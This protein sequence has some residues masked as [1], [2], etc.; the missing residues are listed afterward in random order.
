MKPATHYAN[1]V[2]SA[3]A[4]ATARMLADLMIQHAIG[5]VVIRDDEQRPIGIVTDRDLLC[6]VVACG[7]DPEQTPA[8]EIATKPVH[9]VPNDQPL[10]QVIAL[11]RDANV[12]RAPVVEGGRLVG[13]VTLDDLV[14]QLSREIASLS[15]AATRSIDD[16]LRAGRWKR[17]RE[18]FEDALA[19]L[20]ASAVSAGRE[21]A[22]RVTRELDKLRERLR[23]PE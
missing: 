7:L 2:A 10:E 13:I 6:R 19:S 16:T 18:E 12:R 5:C 3:P 15:T 21:V 9:C 20:E 23:G 8:G 4:T 11:M 14:V 22:G 17:R 1:E